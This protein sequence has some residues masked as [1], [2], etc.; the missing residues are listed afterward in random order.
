MI[1]IN[2]LFHIFSNFSILSSMLC[3]FIN[4]FYTWVDYFNG[5]FN[6]K[7]QL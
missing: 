6:N 4:T 1:F 5:S 2:Y 3:S 7:Y